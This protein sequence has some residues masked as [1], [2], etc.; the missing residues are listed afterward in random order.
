MEV[1]GKQ[2][3]DEDCCHQENCGYDWCSFEL[4]FNCIIL[5]NFAVKVE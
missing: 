1:G 2:T 4:F 3:T 5:E